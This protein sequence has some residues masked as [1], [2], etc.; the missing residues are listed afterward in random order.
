MNSDV[1][2]AIGHFPLL[3]YKQGVV[4]SSSKSRSHK[5]DVM[6]IYRRNHVH[7]QTEQH[8]ITKTD[9][10]LARNEIVRAYML[11][12]PSLPYHAHFHFSSIIGEDGTG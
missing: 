9:A 5:S 8:L 3:P 1:F 6:L 12:C 11:V 7:A 2:T 10:K 4:V